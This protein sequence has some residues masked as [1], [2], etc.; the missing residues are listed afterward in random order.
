[1]CPPLNST[2]LTE[3]ISDESCC[4]NGRRL[5]LVP[6]YTCWLELWLTT[7][8]IPNAPQ[9]FI[10]VSLHCRGRRRSR[11][12]PLRLQRPRVSKRQLLNSKGQ[13]KTKKTPGNR[14]GYGM[15]LGC[16]QL[17]ADVN[18]WSSQLYSEAW[19]MHVCLACSSY[20]V[21]DFWKPIHP[22]WRASL[23]RTVWKWRWCVRL[24]L[25]PNSAFPF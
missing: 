6:Q 25:L 3:K 21:R 13:E 16:H 10:L 4:Y 23:N 20:A 5:P 12:R 11:L 14:C 8:R 9:T 2:N 7:E 17:P 22:P 1:M 19:K 24:T 18:V 15:C